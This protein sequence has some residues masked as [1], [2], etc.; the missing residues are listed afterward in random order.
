MSGMMK[1]LRGNCQTV[2]SN[3]IQRHQSLPSREN[4]LFRGHHSKATAAT[5]VQ[6][7]ENRDHSSFMRP[8]QH[9]L[10]MNTN[11]CE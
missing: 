10:E 7:I 11:H 5:P 6:M 2:S 9:R 1:S 3:E 4:I 8:Q